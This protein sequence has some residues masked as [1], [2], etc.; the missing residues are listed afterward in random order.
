MLITEGY[1]VEIFDQSVQSNMIRA[2]T[3]SLI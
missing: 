3:W 2:T 1:Y